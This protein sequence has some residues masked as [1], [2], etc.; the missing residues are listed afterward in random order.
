MVD[1]WTCIHPSVS[2]PSDPFSTQ[3]SEWALKFESSSVILLLKTLQGLEGY[4]NS[5]PRLQR[6]YGSSL[7]PRPPHGLSLLR[8]LMKLKLH[9]FTF[10]YA[11]SPSSCPL[12]DLLFL[13]TTLPAKLLPS[14]YTANSFSAFMPLLQHT[15]SEV[16]LEYSPCESLPPVL[17]C[18]STYHDVQWFFSPSLLP[19]ILSTL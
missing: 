1:V 4:S 5:S 14:A 10:H 16:F 17:A 12:L 9:R 3:Q 18:H 8:F 19:D 7:P 2:L 15:S 6:P 13:P 11:N